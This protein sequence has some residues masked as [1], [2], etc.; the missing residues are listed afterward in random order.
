MN[1]RCVRD[2][3]QKLV[4]PVEGVGADWRQHLGQRSLVA[5]CRAASDSPIQMIACEVECYG[6]REHT[7]CSWYVGAQ[8]ELASGE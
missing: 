1:N 8:E 7:G 6:I 5:S 3:L 4:W 2:V